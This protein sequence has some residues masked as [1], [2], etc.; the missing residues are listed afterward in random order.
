MNMSTEQ[1]ETENTSQQ[2]K[3]VGFFGKINNCAKN[4]KDTVQL[5]AVVLALGALIVLILQTNSLRRQTDL[6]RNQ[7]SYLA[8]QTQ[9]LQSDYENRTRPYLAIGG[10]AVQAGNSSENLDILIEVEN[11]GSLPMT[12]LYLGNV[13][14]GEPGIVIGGR[15]LSYNKS[16]GEFTAPPHGECVQ[17]SPPE[18][19]E[20]LPPENTGGASAQ[21]RI[22]ATPCYIAPLSKTDFPDDLIFYPGKSG[23]M[24]VTV[25]RSTFEA[26][27]EKTNVMQI[28]L[29]YYYEGSKYYYIATVDK[30]A[31]GS[32]VAEAIGRGN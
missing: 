29:L 25:L 8:E 23:Y 32:W 24:T 12:K 27:C 21:I 2:D 13:S 10:V 19:P 31:D 4:Y 18:S 5:I 17:S 6:L 14:K 7:T 20:S 22:T 3:P 9:I 15:D 28:G 1:G 30:T 11:R 26:T 16:T